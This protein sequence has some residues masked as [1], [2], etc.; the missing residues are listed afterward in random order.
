MSDESDQSLESPIELE[1]SRL[2]A[3]SMVMLLTVRATRLPPAFTG[4]QRENGP[5]GHLAPLPRGEML[6]TF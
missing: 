1:D 2:A 5:A 3:G 6:T 4:L